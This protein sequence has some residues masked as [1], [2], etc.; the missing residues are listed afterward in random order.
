MCAQDAYVPRLGRPPKPMSEGLDICLIVSAFALATGH[1]YPALS[2][3][4]HA[5]SN[6]QRLM[7]C[8]ERAVTITCKLE[9]KRN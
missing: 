5:S 7:S 6:S 1:Q 9:V 4:R 3:L 8:N 2:S